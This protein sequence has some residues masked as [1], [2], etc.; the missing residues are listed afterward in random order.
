MIY[1]PTFSI[2]ELPEDYVTRKF[3][4]LGHNPTYHK[5]NGSYNCGCPICREGKS[6]GKKSRCWWLPQQN[7]IYC[8]N[9]GRG[10]TPY[11][12]IKEAGNLTY[13]DIKKEVLGGEYNI[14]NLDKDDT[15]VISD[16]IAEDIFGVPID[17]VNLFEYINGSSDSIIDKAVKY[18]KR[19]KLD[20]AI[21][22]PDKLYLSHKD[23][24]H[25]DRIIFPFYDS[26]NQIPFYQSRAFGGTDN[27]IMEQVRYLSK[28]GAEKSVFNLDKVSGDIDDIYVFEGPIDACFVKNGV[29]VAGV[30]AGDKQDLTD[31]QRSQL[32]AFSLTHRLV[33]VLDNQQKDKTSEDKTQKLLEQG[34]CVFIWPEGIDY[35][36]FNE[37][38]MKRNLNEIPYELIQKH[39]KCGLIDSFEYKTDLAFITKSDNKSQDFYDGFEF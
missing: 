29:A 2:K 20:V 6:W 22:R 4:S 25:K 37:W 31:L 5:N 15:E 33:W 10:Y 21:N 9:C 32:A 18:I 30:S 23:Y 17:S 35:K 19:R 12:W 34:E 3:Y 1:T 7:L 24:T 39:V 11:S 16:D 36:D 28:V 13:Q 14:I 8:F 27:K 38:A 26:Y